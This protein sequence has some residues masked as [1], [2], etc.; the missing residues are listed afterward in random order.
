MNLDQVLTARGRGALANVVAKLCLIPAIIGTQL[1]RPRDLIQPNGLTLLKSDATRK[2]PGTNFAMP[3]FIAQGDHDEVVAPVLTNRY[4]K[5]LCAAGDKLTYKTFPGA[6]HFDVIA[7]STPDILAWMATI[8]SGRPP[9]ST[10][11]E[12]RL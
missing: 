8:R 6:G 10:C 12:Q 5:R 4:V 2:I 9:P 3:I 11:P 7:A 1:A